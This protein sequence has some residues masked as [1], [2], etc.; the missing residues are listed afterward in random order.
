MDGGQ[1]IDLLLG[2]K[3]N[4]T[5]TGGEGDDTLTGGTGSD[6]FIFT[7]E[8][9]DTVNDFN[10]EDLDVFAFTSANYAGAP[11]AGATPMVTDAN[12]ANV[13]NSADNIIV[14]TLANI[15]ALGASFANTRFA[16]AS[17]VNQLIY[18]ADGDWSEGSLVVADVTLTGNLRAANFAFI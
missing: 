4:D 16:Y 11:P 17:D 13:T 2:D 14:D 8:G 9:T 12:P 6:R 1:G 15:E 10:I 18:D 5:L 7:N 3:G